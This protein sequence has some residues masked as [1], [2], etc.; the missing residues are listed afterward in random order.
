MRGPGLRG[1][2][3]CAGR[4]GRGGEAS[5]RW[6]KRRAALGAVEVLAAA[7]ATLRSWNA[8]RPRVIQRAAPSRARSAWRAPSP[9][10]TES[11]AESP[12]AHL[13]RGRS[14]FRVQEA[15]NHEGGGRRFAAA[16]AV[17]VSTD[18][19][20]RS[21]MRKGSHEVS[22]FSARSSRARARFPKW[23][24]GFPPSLGMVHIHRSA[25]TA[26]A[27]PGGVRRGTGGRG[28]AA[29]DA[30]RARLRRRFAR[31]PPSAASPSSRAARAAATPWPTWPP[32]PRVPHGRVP[33]GRLQP[34]VPG[35]ESGLFQSIVDG[36]GAVVSEHEWDYPP[37]PSPSAPAT[38]S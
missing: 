8:R 1:V 6:A 29:R 38:G 37:R 23:G 36:G 34:A 12:S 25:C 26:W 28:C 11:P 2:A 13:A 16:N 33:R 18:A 14:G 15:R 9:T 5:R 3:P 22:S 20:T 30:V 27:E 32:R 31:L 17:G 10:W 7:A 24:E 21:R 4:G 19:K 35:G